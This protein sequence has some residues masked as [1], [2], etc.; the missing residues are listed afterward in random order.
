LLEELDRRNL[1]L[2]DEIQNWLTNKAFT[3]E[4]MALLKWVNSDE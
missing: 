1:L 2:A 3:K 4:V